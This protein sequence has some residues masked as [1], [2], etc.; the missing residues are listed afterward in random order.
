MTSPAPL[1]MGPWLSAEQFQALSAEQTRHRELVDGEIR[2]TSPSGFEHGVVAATLVH[3][4]HAFAAGKLGVVLSSET[5]FTIRRNPD[6][7]RSPDAAFVATDRLPG[8]GARGGFVELAPDLVVEV[9]SPSDRASDVLSKAL[10]WVDA[11]VRLVWVVDP[12]SRTVT[13]HRP[14]GLSRL[15]RGESAELDGEHVLPGFRLALADIF[16]GPSLPG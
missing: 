14:D 2:D 1:T 15:V 13:V 5:G 3:H 6:T 11:G 16:G 10:D 7:V 12:G 4:L 9:V 8:P